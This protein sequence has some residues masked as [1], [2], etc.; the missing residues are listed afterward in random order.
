MRTFS[1]EH[2]SNSE[3]NPFFFKLA[4]DPLSITNWRHTYILFCQ[5]RCIFF[6]YRG[7]P[8][9]TIKQVR[10]TI[11]IDAN[12]LFQFCITS[13]LFIS[14]QQPC[15]VSS[16]FLS[17]PLSYGQSIKHSTRVCKE[18]QRPTIIFYHSSYERK[19]EICCTWLHFTI[20]QF[21]CSFIHHRLRL[22]DDSIDWSIHLLI[23][24]QHTLYAEHCYQRIHINH[25]KTVSRSTHKPICQQ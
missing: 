13:P 23:H 2:A 17:L 7:V 24:L 21:I 19:N 16:I 9:C 3:H 10:V 15:E 22:L 18:T 6:Q 4:F 14:K 12:C 8:F 11:W 20:L 1:F 25:E 5:F